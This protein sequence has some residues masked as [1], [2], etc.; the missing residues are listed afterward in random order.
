MNTFGTILISITQ[1]QASDKTHGDAGF[2][3]LQFF[4]L[5]KTHEIFLN[6]SYGD[7]FFNKQN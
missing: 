4:F 5:K 1:R 3:F 6:E 2:F 7:F